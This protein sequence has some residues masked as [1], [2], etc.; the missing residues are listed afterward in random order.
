MPDTE[1]QDPY[2]LEL[3]PDMQERLDLEL[4]R[5]VQDCVMACQDRD[6]NIRNLRKELEGWPS[7]PLNQPWPGACRLP[8]T[9]NRE[10]F[11]TSLAAM[12][13]AARQMP[14][15]CLE[16]VES[17]DVDNASDT[18]TWL[19]IKMQEFGF[20]KS[21]YDSLY[22]A[23]EGFY[24]V[25]VTEY[26]QGLRR[27]F[28]LEPPTEEGGEPQLK[29]Q[30]VPEDEGC[31]YRSPDSDDVYLFPITAKGP[32]IEGEFGGATH[33]IERMC[34]TR[35]DLMLGVLRKEYDGEAVSKMF[36]AG[37]V[38]LSY[39][40]D[41]RDENDRDG[42]NT[43]AIT[44]KQEGE[45]WECFQVIGRAPL[46]LD[47]HYEPTIPE[48]L[49]HTDCLWMCCPA[50]N[51]VFKQ[52]YSPYPDSIRPYSFYNV[53]DK[54]NRTQGEGTISLVSPTHRE[55][56]SIGQFGINN[57]NLEASPVMTVAENWLTRYSKWTIAPGRF[58]PRQ[59][60]DPIGPKPI[61]W[62][63]RSQALI[64]PWLQH[65]DNKAQRLVAAQGVNQ[66]LGGKSRKAAEI[67]FAEAMQQVKF[68]LFVANIQRGV[69]ETARITLAIMADHMRQGADHEKASAGGK[70]VGVTPEQIT[71]KYRFLP[72]S[73]SEHISP[74]ARL[75]KQQ[76]IKEIVTEW[77]T[78]YPMWLQ[79]G[80]AGYFY[81]L[82]HRMLIL[83]NERNPERLI[84][85]EPQGSQPDPMAMMI[86]QIQGQGA[87]KNGNGNGNQS[88]MVGNGAGMLQASPFS[89]RAADGI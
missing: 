78:G 50:L 25:Q 12:Y 2:K 35:E 70:E 65:L 24:G 77:W 64:M 56:S 43:G 59:T 52:T 6:E 1:T 87:G 9:T 48:A 26:K 55:M 31:R 19:S 73:S 67:H 36:E 63:V 20:D 60:S 11:L 57:M 44:N 72:Q 47:D 82:Y 39:D 75:A 51:I 40:V 30:T 28:V 29:L 83:A 38:S 68:D 61:Q 42:L 84:G 85:P 23:N 89:P 66:G 5:M 10:L 62:D 79:A 45:P 3:E 53:V 17:E 14:Y 27:S 54:P 74:A 81:A 7:E 46:L 16:A 37:P 4:C 32:Q 18:E 13:S 21:L 76:L 34:L 49:L 15:V 71:K 80:T 86:Q 8:D 22:L 33:V 69:K 58:M 88:P 41:R